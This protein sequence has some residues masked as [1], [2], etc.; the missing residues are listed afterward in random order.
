VGV[1]VLLVCIVGFGC[2]WGGRSYRAPV[3]RKR[4]VSREP[5]YEYLAWEDS[6]ESPEY[7]KDRLYDYDEP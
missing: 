2:L 6:E 7:E 1:A 4:V 3:C 5:D